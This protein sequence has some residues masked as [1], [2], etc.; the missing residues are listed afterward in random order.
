MLHTILKVP[1]WVMETHNTHQTRAL[2]MYACSRTSHQG[3]Q[4]RASQYGNT[5]WDQVIM[6]R[7][8]SLESVHQVYG[9]WLEESLVKGTF[10]SRGSDSAI[11]LWLYLH[12]QIPFTKYELIR[13]VFLYFFT[14]FVGINKFTEK[15]L[16]FWHLHLDLD[17]QYIFIYIFSSLLHTS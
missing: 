16:E 11:M 1:I 7:I 13:T 14:N 6:W 2:Q 12:V 10:S 8:D 9:V 3:C 4:G 15:M 5:R 17:F